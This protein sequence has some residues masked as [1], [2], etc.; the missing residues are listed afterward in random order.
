MM[1]RRLL[2]LVAAVAGVCALPLLFAAG[3]ASIEGEEAITKPSEQREL[4]FSTPGLIV[5]VDVKEGDVVKKDQVLILQDDRIGQEALKELE[6]KANSRLQIDFA[7]KDVEHK[8]VNL[9]RKERG[10]TNDTVSRSEYEEA[11]L[12][13]A[14]A[15]TRLKLAAQEQSLSK[16]ALEKQ[17]AENDQKRMV[18]PIAGAVRKL[19][20]GEGEQAD[21]SKPALIVVQNDPL[22]VE[23]NLETTKAK[24]LKLGQELK[25]RYV[26]E[27]EWRT[28]K[29]IFFDPVVDA[30]SDTQLL[31]LEL[32][33]P[34]N[35]ASGMQAVVTLPER[36]PVEAAA[37]AGE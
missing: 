19:E 3:P 32:K 2:S 8:K 21:P 26:D 36:K 16:I 31:R 11:K 17:K 1:N 25:V 20:A 27:A 34:E 12:E 22:W 6:I 28:A 24:D 5:K 10:L 15:E 13:V 14:L 29:I 35:R 30:A 37:R 7:E 9:A 18:S 4:S 23:M 33:N